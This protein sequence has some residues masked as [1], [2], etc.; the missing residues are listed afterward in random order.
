MTTNL[1]SMVRDQM[2][3]FSGVVIGRAEYLYGCVRVQV[4][5]TGLLNGKPIE[6]EWFDE[7]RLD[8][9]SPAISGGPQVDPE[10]QNDP[11]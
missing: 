1:G 7:Q 4:Q 10:P 2:T 3:G 6:A 11:R 8:A 5:P 9:E